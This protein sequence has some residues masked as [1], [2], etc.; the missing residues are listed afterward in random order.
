[1]LRTPGADVDASSVPRRFQSVTS[2][3]LSR[4]ISR[5]MIE[6]I[7]RGD[8]VPDQELPAE[9]Q[10]AQEFGVSRPVVREAVKHLAVLGLVQSRQGRQTR[11][12]PYEAW[13]HF[14]P[15]IL[16][17]RREVG[18]VEDVLLELLELR[19][20]VELEAVALAAVRATPGDLAD[21]AAALDAL[22]ASLG[23]PRQFTLGDI[24]FHDAILRA[25]KNHLLPRLF[26]LLRPILEFGREI[27][28]T[29]RPHGP[30]ESQAGH[31]A[32]FQAIREGSPEG[33]R[34][35]MEQ[36]LSWTANL[37][38]SQRDVRL[39]LDRARREEGPDGAA[40]GRQDGDSQ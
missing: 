9:D 31:R 6:S 30:T 37:D 34:Q 11:V 33:A 16:A 39:A 32:V 29:T 40:R 38:F 19:R 4:R 35:H 22:D 3:T 7:L 27:S 20:M 12:A 24:A 2:E 15:E 23:D 21:M 10:L 18:A 17:A 26:D 28:V 14:S 1:V 5:Q 13:N 25:T 36:H 8:F